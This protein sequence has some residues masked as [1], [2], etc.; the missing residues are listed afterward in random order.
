MKDYETRFQIE[1]DE[2]WR[3]WSNI[4]PEVHFKEDWNV[5]I[6]PPFGGALIRFRVIKNDNEVSIYLDV[7]DSL[8]FVGKPY[9]ELYPISCSSVSC[10][11]D[12]HRFFINDVDG[13]ID[14]ISMYLDVD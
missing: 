5:K 10:D 3:E 9:W 13:L 12:T 1:Q 11:T 7:D 6:I 8:G 4:I 14:S 2:K